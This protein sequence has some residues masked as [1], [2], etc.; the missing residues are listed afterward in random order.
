MGF[1]GDFGGRGEGI[2]WESKYIRP[3]NCAFS[4]VFGP[5]LMRRIVAFCMG[6]AICHRRKFGQVWESPAPL[7][8]FA[9]KHCGRKAP[10]WTFDYDMEKS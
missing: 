10:L 1:W 7:S 5:H 4:D 6:I 3:Q 8:E 9:G 2:R